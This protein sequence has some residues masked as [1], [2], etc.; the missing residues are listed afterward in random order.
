MIKQGDQRHPELKETQY[1]YKCFNCITTI[2]YITGINFNS[3]IVSDLKYYK[4]E[5]KMLKTKDT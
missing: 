1:N 2:S 4:L 3:D 5:G